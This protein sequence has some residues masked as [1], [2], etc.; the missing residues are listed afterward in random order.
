MRYWRVSPCRPWPACY[1][2]ITSRLDVAPCGPGLAA[3]GAGGFS[4]PGKTHEAAADRPAAAFGR[5]GGRAGRGGGAGGGVRV[6]RWCLRRRAGHDMWQAGISGNCNN[7]SFCGADGLGG[8]CGWVEFDRF[9]DGTITGDAQFT[10]CHHFIGPLAGWR[11]AHAYSS[12]ERPHMSEPC[13]DRHRGDIGAYRQG[14]H[15]KRHAVQITARDGENGGSSP[16]IADSA[17][18]TVTPF[19]LPVSRISSEYARPS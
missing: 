2:W 7:P 8:F 17:R 4:E 3:A 18:M 10:D 9:A 14:S 1:R 15:V 16:P 12:A 11:S 19:E 6:A 13:P 5:A